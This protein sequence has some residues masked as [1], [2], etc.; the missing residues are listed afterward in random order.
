MDWSA[1]PEPSI[2]LASGRE[3]ALTG[4]AWMVLRRL[5]DGKAIPNGLP[6][7]MEMMTRLRSAGLVDGNRPTLEGSE[8]RRL[9]E[10][11]IGHILRDHTID[12][13]DDPAVPHAVRLE[14]E[15]TALDKLDSWIAVVS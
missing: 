10:Q 5:C 13:M 2:R 7:A 6:M 3:V 8:A 11:F 9:I 1:P 14:C 15:L 12:W 4:Y